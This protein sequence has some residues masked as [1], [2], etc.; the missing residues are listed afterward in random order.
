MNNVTKY[1]LEPFSY[2]F[3][4][5][6]LGNSRDTSNLTKCCLELFAYYSQE[7]LLGGLRRRNNFTQYCLEILSLL[8]KSCQNYA[9]PRV[10]VVRFR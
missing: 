2:E 5:A 9:S 10:V 3:Y 8:W 7:A 1:C 6:L 4:I